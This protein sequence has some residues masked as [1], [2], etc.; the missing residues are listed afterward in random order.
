MIKF[1]ASTRMDGADIIGAKNRFSP[2]WNASLKYNIHKE[3]F[4]T[5]FG[6]INELAVRFSYGYTG[7]IDKSA[8][9]L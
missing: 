9:P 2:L 8:L 4:M 1:S 7:S 6:W 3:N 5:R